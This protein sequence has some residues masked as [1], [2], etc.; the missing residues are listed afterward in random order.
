MSDDFVE[1]AAF[2]IPVVRVRAEGGAPS[3]WRGVSLRLQ[4]VTEPGEYTI[5]FK[6]VIVPALRAEKFAVFFAVFH[7]AASSKSSRCTRS[8][9][10]PYSK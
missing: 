1:S 2:E 3:V 9:I 8:N 7:Y 6:I 10:T 4:G 5:S